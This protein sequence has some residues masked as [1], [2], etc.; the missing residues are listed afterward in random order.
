MGVFESLYNSLMKNKKDK[1][2]ALSKLDILLETVDFYSADTS[3]RSYKNGYCTYNGDNGTHCAFG[4]CMLPKYQ[5]QGSNLKYNGTNVLEFLRENKKKLDSVLQEKYRGH[6]V[7]FWSLIQR[8][9]DSKENWDDSG[10]T[11]EGELAVNRIIE[12]YDLKTK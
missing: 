4:R 2:I 9:H 5:E 3:R 11:F 1:A 12:C 7:N 8:L 10:I 6:D